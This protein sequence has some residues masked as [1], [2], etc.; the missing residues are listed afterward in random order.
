MKEVTGLQNCNQKVHSSIVARA[1]RKLVLYVKL[2]V[3][4][5]KTDDLKNV[6]GHPYL[7]K[8]VQLGDRNFGVQLDRKNEI[9]WIDY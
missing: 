4:R 6:V 9:L 8:R 2:S 1:Q 3:V 5:W 7:V